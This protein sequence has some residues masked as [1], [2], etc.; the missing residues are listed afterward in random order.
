MF[1]STRKIT[2]RQFMALDLCENGHYFDA[3]KTARCPFCFAAAAPTPQPVETDASAGLVVGWLVV[4]EG[5]GQGMDFRLRGGRN[6]IGSAAQ[7]A[8]ALTEDPVISS[9]E[10]AFILY[11]GRSN[12]FALQPGAGRGLCYRNGELAAATVPLRA[13][14]KILIGATTLLFVPLAGDSFRWA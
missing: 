6:D 1:D 9:H 4:I 3:V 2:S 14:D 13:G 8:V 5:P 10:H 7:S 11:D 12:G